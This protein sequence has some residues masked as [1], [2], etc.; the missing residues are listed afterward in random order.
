MQV[1]K[2]RLQEEVQTAKMLD[3][4]PKRQTRL[5]QTQRL[6][7]NEISVQNLKTFL[8]NHQ[9][10]CINWKQFLGLEFPENFGPGFGKSSAATSRLASQM[11]C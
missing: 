5:Q 8:A 9:L 11:K 4:V 10:T 1:I 3:L 6:K 7:R 2:A